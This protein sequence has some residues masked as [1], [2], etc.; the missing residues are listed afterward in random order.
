MSGRSHRHSHGL[1]CPLT[2]CH[3]LVIY[4]I[5]R[6]LEILVCHMLGRRNDAKDFSPANTAIEIM[7]CMDAKG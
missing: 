3:P 6:L 1:F 2:L 4:G 5:C 7:G